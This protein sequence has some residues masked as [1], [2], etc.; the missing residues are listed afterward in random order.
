MACTTVTFH[1]VT[2]NVFQ[3]LKEK[4]KQYGAKVPPGPDG[5]ITGH[6]MGISITGQFHWDEQAATLTITIT[7]KPFFL[8]CGTISGAIHNAVHDCGGE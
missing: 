7:D 5:T 8:P 2:A 3:C 6:E 1:G 4:L